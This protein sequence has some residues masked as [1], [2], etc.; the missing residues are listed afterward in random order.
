[1][2]FRNQFLIFKQYP[3]LV[4]LDSAST[5]QRP[6][7][8][9]R[10][11][12]DY[13]LKMN[14]NV[15]RG[16]Y[17]LSERAT[18]AY[19]AVREKAVDFL[20]APSTEQ[21]VFTKG[22]TEALNMVAQGWGGKFLKKG[23]EVVLTLLEH[24]SNIVPWQIVAEKTG[25]VIR[26][27][28][29]KENGELDYDEMEKLINDRTKIVSVTG[30]SNTLGTMVD[31]KR[32][33]ALG[34]GV[35]AKVCVDAAQYAAHFKIDV[36]DL[37]VDF[38]AFSSHKIYGPTGAGVLYA[39]REI[40][41][42][43]DP[44]LGGGDMIKTVTTEG[45]TWNDLPW[46]FEAG[47]PNIAQVIGMG[48]AI[49]VIQSIGFDWIE[50]HDHDLHEYAVKVLEELPYVTILGP[51]DSNLQ[52]GAISFLVK[53]VH[54]HDVSAILGSEQVCVRAG[55]HCTMPLMKA[56]DVIST[57]RVSFGVYNTM[58]DVD[59]LVSALS[60]VAEKFKI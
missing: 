47:T 56:L 23:D 53:E 43:M 35:G 25:A 49:D 36:Q 27:V 3:E 31:L 59:R 1:M 30:L 20:N 12:E 10:A 24:H 52:R 5:T 14:A 44:W 32:V 55:H 50:Q 33:V 46:K 39:K 7:E 19:E 22:T 28:P 34:H 8:V 51:K 41:E 40:L 37:D 42:Q 57:T 9:L 2:N 45:S 17:D 48:A 60:V 15:H 18:T 6:H 16:L 38:L 21:I 54:P 58:D 11:V 26:F 29:I 13:Y 4:Y